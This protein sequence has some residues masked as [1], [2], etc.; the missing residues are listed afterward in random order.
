MAPATVRRAPY[1]DFLQP[2][3]HRR[4]STVA[5]IILAIAYAQSV[6]LSDW[7]S[8]LWSW[9]PLGPAGFR[10]V[11]LFFCGLFILVLRIGQYHVGLRTSNSGFQTFVAN[12]LSSRTIW[13]ILAHVSSAWLFSQVYMWSAS[14][15]ANLGWITYFNGDRAR[16]NE[17]TIFFFVHFLVFGMARGIVHVALDRDH[18]SLGTVKPPSA[19]GK[20]WLALWTSLPAIMVSSFPIALFAVMLTAVLYFTAIRPFAWSI[21]LMTFRPFYSLPK[22]NILPVSWPLTASL[23]LRCTLLTAILNMMWGVGNVAFSIFLVKPPFKNGKP[24]TSDAKDP[25]GSLLNG[26]KSKKLPIKC[27]AMWELAVIACDFEDRR[28]VIYEDFERKDGS[29]WSQACAAC[30]EVIKEL[31]SRMDNYG[32]TPVPIQPPA[33]SEAAETARQLSRKS[34]KSP[35]FAEATASRMGVVGELKTTVTEYVD[36]VARDPNQPSRLS[37]IGK[38]AGEARLRLREMKKQLA[39]EDSSSASNPVQTRARALLAS[40]FGWPFRQEYGRRLTAAVLGGPYGEPSLYINAATALSQLAVHS[41]QEDK[42]GNVQ[43]DVALIVRTL[44][45]VTSKLDTFKKSFPLHWTDVQKDRSSPEVDAVLEALRDGLSDVVLKFERYSR[46]L[47]LTMADMRL[48]REAIGVQAAA[49]APAMN[50]R[51]SPQMQQV[52]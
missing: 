50:R 19:A 29:M 42:Y 41:L 7:S 45:A 37:P 12:A 6:L 15:S 40:P 39:E 5:T 8:W 18:I 34:L 3:L 44:T 11:F 33:Q 21:A 27:F 17:K 9:F 24:L 35:P 22:Y 2:A 38:A 30:V 4:F 16:L 36:K 10:A 25:N 13:A 32:K 46:D 23:V 26:L 48:A 20:E 43:R 51:A 14:S 47:R 31:E 49:E 1:K 28:K 52:R